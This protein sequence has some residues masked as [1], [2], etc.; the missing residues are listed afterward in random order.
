MRSGLRQ[1]IRP[2]APAPQAPPGPEPPLPQGFQNAI[3]NSVEN[4]AQTAGREAAKQAAKTQLEE[5]I[6]L[7]EKQAERQAMVNGASVAE[8]QAAKLA[9]RQAII[10]QAERQAAQRGLQLVVTEGGELAFT[11]VAADAAVGTAAAVGTETAAIGTLAGTESA[12]V[13]SGVGIPIA[14][15]IALTTLPIVGAY[16]AEQYMEDPDNVIFPDL[17]KKEEEK[18][19]KTKIARPADLHV[20]ELGDVDDFDDDD[21]DMT[22]QTWT[23][24]SSLVNPTTP[25]TPLPLNPQRRP[26]SSIYAHKDGSSVYSGK[27]PNVIKPNPPPLSK[28]DQ[29]AEQHNIGVELPD[30]EKGDEKAVSTD[31]DKSLLETVKENL[32]SVNQKMVENDPFY[33]GPK[34]AKAMTPLGY[35]NEI[36]N[37]DG[38]KSTFGQ[39]LVSENTKLPYHDYLMRT[40]GKSIYEE[41]EG[42]HVLKEK[43]S[44]EH[45]KNVMNMLD[46]NHQKD[47]FEKPEGYEDD[48]NSIILGKEYANSKRRKAFLKAQK[49]KFRGEEKYKKEKYQQAE[50]ER[51]VKGLEKGATPYK[52]GDDRD[53]SDP[54]TIMY[55]EDMDKH[56]LER[57][58]ASKHSREKD[59]YEQQRLVQAKNSA[60]EEAESRRDPITPATGAGERP[61][62]EAATMR[63]LAKMRKKS[64]KGSARERVNMGSGEYDANNYSTYDRPTMNLDGNPN[65]TDGPLEMSKKRRRSQTAKAS[66]ML[67]PSSSSYVYDTGGSSL[68]TRQTFQAKVGA[69]VRNSEADYAVGKIG[70]GNVAFDAYKNPKKRRM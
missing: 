19:K 32:G 42:K 39:D 64:S 8:Q 63:A 40:Y 38:S 54:D 26:T 22:P 20:L 60:K 15:A 13:G 46:G 56:E 67:R 61:G 27:T 12:L 69:E 7:A 21:D 36:E 51:K 6:F 44:K 24:P 25:P 11:E 5:A 65:W 37:A 41:K 34:G 53:R 59:E 33:I 52:A 68:A 29:L 1:R 45:E 14:A 50:L 28:T 23:R 35:P 3:S 47:Y 10:S 43:Y 49:E 2:P 4:G 9:A 48:F 16:E 31:A 30:I 70:A 57:V 62:R 17:D 18:N 66:D 55:K 58:R